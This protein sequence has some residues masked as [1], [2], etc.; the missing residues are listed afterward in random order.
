[1]SN[2]KKR[3]SSLKNIDN[4]VL[5]NGQ[6][7]IST[8][9]FYF[10]FCLLHVPLNVKAY[11]NRLNSFRLNKNIKQLPTVTLSHEPRHV[12]V[13]LLLIIYQKFLEITADPDM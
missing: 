3:T 4:N 7:Q 12:P 13:A 2:I 6:W 1:M 11:G 10:L 5:Q 8:F 9:D